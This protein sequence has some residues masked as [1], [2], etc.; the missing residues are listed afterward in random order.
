MPVF[1]HSYRHLERPLREP[2]LRWLVIAR[3]G[4]AERLA[5]RWF[6]ALLVVAFLPFLYYTVRLF[7]ELR[8]PDILGENM[9]QGDQFL[10]YLAIS[11]ASFM[12]LLKTQMIFAFLVT[13]FAGSGLVS[14]DLRTR[15]LPLYMSKPITRLD[16]VLG[17]FLV[18]AFFVGLVTLVPAELLLFLKAVTS[19]NLSFLW[20]NPLLPARIALSS[21]AIMSVM[22]IL[23][24]A[25]S[26]LS[27]S[28]WLPGLGFAILYLF[29]RAFS[30]LLRL[31]L[32]SHE[33]VLLSLRDNLA[34]VTEG[35]FGTPPAVG[36]HWILSGVMLALL[37]A[38]SA[39]VLH[40]RIRGV[41]V[42]AS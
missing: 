32:R 42:V 19:E 9:R 5:R 26:S 17:K 40:V 22:S 34:R 28:A 29:S 31:M 16:Y 39:A 8:L 35:V 30:G 38:V 24:L 41:E 14:G 7:L 2:R 3:L 21:A 23:M 11:P 13:I 18:C 6:D 20:E 37:V 1:D 27:R 4:I 12:Q 15:A 36:P 25:M 10:E 33:P